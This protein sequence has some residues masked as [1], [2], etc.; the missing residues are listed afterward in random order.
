M[1]R[2]FVNVNENGNVNAAVYVNAEQQQFESNRILDIKL[3]AIA[4][5][6]MRKM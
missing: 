2:F 3:K 4:R 5:Q 1:P 6:K